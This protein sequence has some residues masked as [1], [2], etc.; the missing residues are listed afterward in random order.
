MLV[1]RIISTLT[2]PAF[3]IV[4]WVHRTSK[5]GFLEMRCDLNQIHGIKKKGH[6]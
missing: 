6:P 4:R 2:K 3:D 1:F 5:I